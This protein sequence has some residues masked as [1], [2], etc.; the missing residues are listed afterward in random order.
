M[1][2]MIAAKSPE[3]RLYSQPATQQDRWVIETLG[4]ESGY[5]V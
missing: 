4:R 3:I 1:T 5:F 2:Q